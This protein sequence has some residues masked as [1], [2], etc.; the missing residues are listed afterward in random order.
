MSIPHPPPKKTKG[1]TLFE[2][3]SSAYFTSNTCDIGR[4]EV[5]WYPP[6]GFVKVNFDGSIKHSLA[7]KGFILQDWTDKVIKAG[8]TN[9]G[10]TSIFIT[11]ARALRDGV[12]VAIQAG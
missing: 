12:Q 6:C 8:T 10:N 3:K 9:Y 4:R 5:R 7:A 2:G 1:L 11:E